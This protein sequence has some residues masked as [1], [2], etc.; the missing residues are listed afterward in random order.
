[1]IC[2]PGRTSAGKGTFDS[3]CKAFNRSD[4]L[5]D[6]RFATTALRLKHF[7]ELYALVDAAASQF[8]TYDDLDRALDAIGLACGEIRT[9]SEVAATE[10]A[11]ARGAIAT[12]SDRGDGTLR[13]PNSPWHFSDAWTGVRGEARY[14]G[15]DNRGVL[16]AVAGYS[17]DDVDRLETDGV[18]SSRLPRR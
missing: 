10:W 1:M 14:R 5:G 4:L 12:I 9:P 6:P 2:S 18:L 17:D 3:F 8:A 15:E 13:I 7:D 11:E 16:T